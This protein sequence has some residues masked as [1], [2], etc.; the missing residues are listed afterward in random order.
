MHNFRE[1]FTAYNPRGKNVID[2]VPHQE[3]AFY[4]FT[5]RNK[6]FRSFLPI[7]KG[8]KSQ[9][10]ESQKIFSKRV[11]SVTNHDLLQDSPGN[12]NS[13][14]CP[15]GYRKRIAEGAEFCSPTKTEQEIAKEEPQCSGMSNSI[16]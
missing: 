15:E 3:R 11:E 8:P 5:P 13:F 10:P 16:L 9:G 2:N 12:L 14:V 6:L 1:P 4:K 7:L